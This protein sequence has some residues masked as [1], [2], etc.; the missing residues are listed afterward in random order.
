MN[1]L[2]VVLAACC[3]L[4]PGALSAQD[5]PPKRPPKIGYQYPGSPSGGGVPLRSVAVPRVPR[6]LAFVDVTEVESNNIPAEATAVAIGDRISGVVSP[7]GDLD[8]FVFTA[9]R[10]VTV[11]IDVAASV[12]RSFR[13]ASA[14]VVFSDPVARTVI[15]AASRYGKG[16]ADYLTCPLSEAQYRN[17]IAEILA[18]E[19]VAFHPFES[20]R[21]FEGCLPIEE[22]AARGEM[23]ARSRSTPSLSP[24]AGRAIMGLMGPQSSA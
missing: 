22:S 11:D 12:P 23:I 6:T 20:L 17:F 15:Y 16:E 19:K 2:I 5:R 3:L 10:G 7:A 18:A 13:D 24:E 4:A 1:R 9:D 8:F 14:P 21:A